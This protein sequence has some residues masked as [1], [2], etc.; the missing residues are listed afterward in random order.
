MMQGGTD[1]KN[2]EDPSRTDCGNCHHFL[3]RTL[4]CIPGSKFDFCLDSVDSALWSNLGG[5]VIIK[6]F[7]NC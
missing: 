6:F 2:L 4:L 1:A 3:M 7:K 5:H